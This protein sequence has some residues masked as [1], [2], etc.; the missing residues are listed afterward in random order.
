MLFVAADS[1][2]EWPEVMEMPSITAQ[3]TIAEVRR[4]FQLFG[5]PQHVVTDNGPTFVSDDFQI[6][7][8]QNGVKH[9]VPHPMV[10]WN[11]SSKRSSQP[12]KLEALVTSH[13]NIAFQIS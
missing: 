9:I 12:S 1:H 13:C 4:L 5:L 10:P 7:L 2:S 8:K 11:D 3:T 6:F